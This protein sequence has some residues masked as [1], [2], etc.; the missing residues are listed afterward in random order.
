MSEPASSSFAKR[1]EQTMKGQRLDIR[2]Q[3]LCRT[4]AA[5]SSCALLLLAVS[6]CDPKEKADKL[7]EKVSKPAA[8]QKAATPQ[9][10]FGQK[11]GAIAV[12]GAAAETVCNGINDDPEDDAVV[13]DGF[14]VG[15]PCGT[16]ACH[17]GTLVCN[18][19]GTDTTC[20]AMPGGASDQSSSEG[21]V[22]DSV[23]ND[24]DGDTDE[25][26][27]CVTPCPTSVTESG[28]TWYDSSENERD[29]TLTRFSYAGSSPWAGDGTTSAPYALQFDGI[30]DQ[31]SLADSDGIR[32]VASLSYELWVNIDTV[33][34]ATLVQP[35]RPGPNGVVE[36]FTG[37]VLIAHGN[38]KFQAYTQTAIG[39]NL[40]WSSYLNSDGSYSTN[41]WYHV[42][43]TFTAGTGTRLYVNGAEQAQTYNTA[44]PLYYHPSTTLPVTL[45]S[46]TVSAANVLAGRLARVRIWAKGLT[47]QEVENLYRE[48]AASFG[49]TAPAASGSTTGTVLA[50]LDASD[51]QECTQSSECDDGIG[52][53]VDTCTT[54]RCES[55]LPT[56]VDCSAILAAN[57]G[58]P[59]DEYSIDPDGGGGGT[60]FDVYCDM[61]TL[62]G[63]W[64]LAAV[65]SDDGQH[66]WT[67]NNRR[68]W[69]TNTTT[70]G[71]LSNLN[72]DMK[73]RAHHEVDFGDLL[74]VHAPSGITAQY[75]DVSDNTGSFADLITATPEFNC[76]AQANVDP[77]PLTG[78]TLT[79]L[80]TLC[81][82][83]LYLNTQ[84]Q[85]GNTNPATICIGDSGS[86]ENA[87]GPV[88]SAV[89]NNSCPLDDP[90]M[91]S[92]LGPNSSTVPANGLRT[93]ER[94]TLGFGNPANLNTGSSGTGQNNMRIYVRPAG[95]CTQDANCDDSDDATSDTCVSNLCQHAYADYCRGTQNPW[96][97]ISG[98]GRHANLDGTDYTS[99]SGWV[100]DGT[101]GDPYALEL[102]QVDDLPVL[103]DSTSGLPNAE[104]TFEVWVRPETTDSETYISSRS[105]VTNQTAGMLMGVKLDLG[106]PR[107]RLLAE[108]S[109]TAGWDYD[110]NTTTAPQPGVWA[111]VIGTFSQSNG[112]VALYVNGALEDSAAA[113]GTL[114]HDLTAGV[115]LGEPGPTANFRIHSR[116]GRMRIWGRALTAA[117]VLNV[118]RENA[119]RFGHTTAAA[120]ASVTGDN[121]AWL[122]A[123]YCKVECTQDTDCDD[124]DPV[125]MDVCDTGAVCVS[126]YCGIDIEPTTNTTVTDTFDGTSLSAHWT[127]PA[128]GNL[129]Q[130]H[131][132]A[133]GRYQVANSNLSPDLGQHSTT[134]GTWQRCFYG[135]NPSYPYGG[136][137]R[138]NQV[139]WA[140]PIGTGDYDVTSNI[141]WGTSA[142]DLGHGTI[143]LVDS[144]GHPEVLAGW[145]DGHPTG[146]GFNALWRRPASNPIHVADVTPPTSAYSGTAEWR[147]VRCGGVYQSS[148]YNGQHH[149]S[150][151]NDGD[152]VDI[153]RA[154]IAHTV[155]R[156]SDGPLH[157]YGTFNIFDFTV[158]YQQ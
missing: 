134:V 120:T 31:V 42:V 103:R 111:H 40:T 13:D 116:L 29:G 57:P 12:A 73:S 136:R 122:E 16:G 54:S 14:A 8:A 5:A 44:L 157:S 9:P 19:C 62:G 132:V 22:C 76:Y 30:D 85:D 109:Q 86:G 4:M 2:L 65:V 104:L 121:W 34:S 105:G 47:A 95:F 17:G 38:G 138:P 118:Y 106:A 26:L 27:V 82:T 71:S 98:N 39:T 83:N 140:L 78:G 123:A 115:L 1:M 18:S 155:C 89:N 110:L 59:S 46:E 149:R 99:A 152:A 112:A 94:N 91:Y 130:S 142:A 75:D 79:Q 48:S 126:G 151:V 97:D 139:G 90:G 36:N 6:G 67:W 53:T 66:N 113:S 35:G 133:S 32:A 21:S 137:D 23:D 84:E 124:G 117:E 100:G 51:C 102:D 77:W 72:A 88:W 81:D 128:Y 43:S 15:E 153:A 107:F 7:P 45:G 127:N 80:G 49:I 141:S 143:G 154:V 144:A 50:H 150:W 10:S 33:N 20:P 55:S 58:A 28:D 92:S 74:F 3:R 63:G 52:Y 93:Q 147:I 61:T 64:T 69:D 24:C 146:P 56:G 108:A 135:L 37:M 60:S 11:R 87:H 114:A 96:T 158:S 129:P 41:T 145:Q 125:T 156:R 148:F 131:N 101:A 70:F 68:Y 25:S 119:A